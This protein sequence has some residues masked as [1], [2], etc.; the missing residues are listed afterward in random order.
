[1]VWWIGAAWAG[2]PP[3][4]ELAWNRDRSELVVLAPEGHELSADAPADLRLTMA[5]RQIHF[6][7][8]G[9]GATRGLPLGEVRGTEL[10]GE[11]SAVLCRKADGLC[12][13]GTWAL[14]GAVPG[15]KKGQLTLRV[16]A[17]DPGAHASPFGPD[18]TTAS[19]DAA[20]ARAASD[21]KLVLL[22][23]SAVWCPPCTVLAAEVLHADPR[24][25]ELDGFEVA[26]VDVD[27]ES[28]WALKDRYA[29]GGYPTLVVTDA[30]GGELT[31][32]VGYPGRDEVLAWLAGAGD[33]TLAADLARDP[34]TVD[35]ARAAGLAWRLAQQGEGDAA[36]PWLARA[37]EGGDDSVE[38]HLARV[39]TDPSA[40]ELEW[41]AEHA[42]ERAS[43]WAFAVL[44]PHEEHP[45]LAARVV[46]IAL[47]HFE[48]DALGDALYLAAAVEPDEARQRR[49]YA[50]AASAV[51]GGMGE[52]EAV[53]KASL[54]WLARLHELSGDVARAITTL[55]EAS[56]RWAPE[57]TYDLALAA[58][59]VRQVRHD[60]ALT[61]A[62]RA[63][64]RSW[65]DLRLRVAAVRA[66]A[67]AG[68][69]RADEAATFA[70]RIL[71]E[72]PAPAEGLDVRTHKYRER[73]A[74]WLSDD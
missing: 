9:L 29:V 48:P 56:E 24:P 47:R 46:D 70:A 4:V 20:F 34:A 2:S 3:A 60:E 23:F 65:G 36:A 5:D 30:E 49:L 67:L 53:D 12:E 44:G 43:A 42:P 7:L 16:S 25:P 51:Q 1:M 73:L 22:D 64:D 58:L 37:T 11:L 18:A 35:P 69:D 38:L 66:E 63:L 72:R 33:D 21:G 27:H 28:S 39:S 55:T 8:S 68:L 26:I 71:D 40:A 31:R 13:P 6:A 61:A 54:E 41:L 59:L 32:L 50:A 15:D 52:D 45:E 62:D 74:R 17:P 14:G 57:P 19:A 10:E